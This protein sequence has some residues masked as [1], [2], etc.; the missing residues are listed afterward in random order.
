MWDKRHTHI[1][2]CIG[3][4]KEFLFFQHAIKTINTHTHTHTHTHTQ[5]SLWMQRRIFIFPIWDKVLLLSF[6]VLSTLSRIL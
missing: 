2:V 3:R 5:N 1:C 4:E 6:G